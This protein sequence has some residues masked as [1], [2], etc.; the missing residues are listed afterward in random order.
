MTTDGILLETG[1]G[2]IYAI[3]PEVLASCLLR[4]ADRDKAR[5]L[6]DG[7][8]R[9]DAAADASVD[10]EGFGD[11]W[12][13]HGVFFGPL[14][15]TQIGNAIGGAANSGDESSARQAKKQPGMVDLNDMVVR[16]SRRPPW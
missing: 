12:S 6:L 3:A 14:I 11:P 1:D 2:S 4:G 9:D 15:G 16:P 13:V 8:R 7:A 10:V 5:E